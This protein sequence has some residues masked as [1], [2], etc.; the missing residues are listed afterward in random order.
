MIHSLHNFH[1]THFPKLP[2]CWRWLSLVC[3]PHYFNFVVRSRRP[4]NS[5]VV[6]PPKPV[7]MVFSSTPRESCDLDLHREAEATEEAVTEQGA[8]F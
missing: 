3:S 4:K 5:L 6:P 2:T 8:E 1:K 7:R